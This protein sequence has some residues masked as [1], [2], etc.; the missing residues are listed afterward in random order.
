MKIGLI[1]PNKDR[2]DKTV[3][4]G[5]GYIAAFSRIVHPDLEFTILDTRIAT[6][7]QTK[8]FYSSNFDLIGITVLSPIYYEAVSIVEN[9]NKNFP[10]IPI[11]LGGPYVTTI[12]EEI[13]DDMNVK[14][15]VYGEGEITFSEL[16][17]HLKQQ[18]NI[19]EINGLMYKL[20]DNKISKNPPRE[21]INNL[22]TIPFPAY[23]LFKMNKYP[24][25][26]I[27]TTRGC[28]YKCVFCNSTSIWDWKWRKRDVEHIVEEIQFLIKNY[29]KKVFF[30]F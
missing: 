12:M 17:S 23:D 9:I 19:E 6:K 22:D 16:I 28:P 2:K 18:K 24:M 7:N 20:N 8:K 3:H 15:A 21:Q 5:L 29:G 14:Y 11:C 30:F 25:H 26:R 4:L 10:N 13:F 1:F 27:T